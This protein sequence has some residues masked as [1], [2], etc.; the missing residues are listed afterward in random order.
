MDVDLVAPN[1]V[2][3]LSA[4]NN[5]EAA[6]YRGVWMPE[7][8]HDP[9]PLLAMCV[10]NTSTVDLGTNIAVAFARNPMTTAVLAN[11]LQLYAFGCPS[12]KLGIF[13]YGTG[14]TQ[15]PLG[16]GFRCVASP[17]FRLGATSTDDFGDATF[18]VDFTHHPANA[19]P[20]AIHTGS[21][22]HF[23]LWFRDPPGGGALTDGSARM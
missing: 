5:A 1:N 9:F 8:K 11:D 15:T 3:A 23:Q 14:T 21:T 2:N 16:N 20:G 10:Q 18:D 22:Q 17:F 4:A 13:I 7:M 6:G 12:H 19:G